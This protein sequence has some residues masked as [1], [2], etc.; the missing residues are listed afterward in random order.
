MLKQAILSIAA[1]AGLGLVGYASGATIYP[2]NDGFES[3]D[4]SANAGSQSNSYAYAN[5]SGG[6]GP[7]NTSAPG[8]GWTFTSGGVGIASNGSAFGVAG[9]TNLN[10]NSGAGNTTSQYGQAG[11]LQG[12]DGSLT[13]N[14]SQS[15]TLPAGTTS[16]TLNFDDEGR[17]NS[18]PNGIN[19]YLDGVQVGGT[20]TPIS[21]TS[22]NTETVSLGAISGAHTIAFAGKNPNGGDN[23]SFI[24]NVR[25]IAVPEPASFGIL[26]LGALSLLARRRRV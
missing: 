12:G 18:G 6:N 14:I 13:A 16:A 24:D 25:I 7:F 5:Q 8:V 11:L 15:I 26:G 22:F 21:N 1:L 9:A 3:P 19:V 23:T 2:V 17:N 4:V 20:L 10:N